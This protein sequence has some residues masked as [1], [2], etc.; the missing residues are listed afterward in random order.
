MYGKQEVDWC[1]RTIKNDENFEIEKLV[2]NIKL[3]TGTRYELIDL[4]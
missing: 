4:L 3:I 1:P 2:G